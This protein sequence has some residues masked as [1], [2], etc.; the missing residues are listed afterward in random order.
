MK[1]F[2]TASRRGGN[3]EHGQVLMLAVV[4]LVLV[5]IAILL[6]FDVQN[7]ISGKIKGQNGVDAAA[8]TGA[9]WQRHSLNLIGE[10]NLIRAT[11]VL[12]SEPFLAPGVE[13]IVYEVNVEG[14]DIEIP[15]YRPGPTRPE[16]FTRFPERKEFEDEDGNIDMAKLITEII[17]VEKEIK[18]LANLDDLVSQLQTRISF[19]GPLIGFGA[20]QQAAKNNGLMFREAQNDMNAM[21]F[22]Y[23]KLLRENGEIHEN[24]N[25]RYINGYDWPDR[26]LEMLYSIVGYDGSGGI[27]AGTKFKFIGMPVFVSD[28]PS[29]LSGYLGSRYFY[30]QVLGRNWCELDPVLGLDFNGNWWNDFKKVDN[31]DFSK[32]S[33]ILPVHI[34]FSYGYHEEGRVSSDYDPST[35]Y[36]MALDAGAFQ[37]TRVI[38]ALKAVA[39]SNYDL[40][41]SSFNTEVPFDYDVDYSEEY[42]S[43]EENT[44]RKNY[45][46]RINSLGTFNDEDSDRRYNLLPLLSWATY[47]TE[48]RRYSDYQ[49][50]WA[51][52]CLRTPLQE[53]MDYQSGALSYFVAKQSVRTYSSQGSPMGPRTGSGKDSINLMFNADV[54]HPRDSYLDQIKMDARAKPI[55][56][57]ETEKG[58]VAPFEAGRLVLPVFTDTALIPVSLEDDAGSI[59]MGDIDWFYYLTEFVPL[60]SESSSIDEAWERATSM[61]DNHCWYY[62]SY[63]NALKLLDDPDFRKRGLDWLDTPVE[64]YTDGNGNRHPLRIR[65]D[66]CHLTGGHIQGTSSLH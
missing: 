5:V 31:N 34:S 59:S 30:Q 8:L 66:N 40:F 12:V 7:V 15:D 9:E 4:A 54:G 18:Y 46:S 43:P 10:L 65:R 3:G 33:E 47:D 17:R 1:R 27:A 29:E 60:L 39:G 19:V 28:P 2:G 42:D 51:E 41:S 13:S 35:P 25:L 64:W 48:W 63:K 49:K 58:W 14:L 16:D 23:L 44:R 45:N 50:E 37:D 22:E 57:I 20:A 56:R 52:D 32:Q 21:F 6:L 61:N 26:Y 36:A 11:G 55:G 53:G 62:E 38:D 24:E